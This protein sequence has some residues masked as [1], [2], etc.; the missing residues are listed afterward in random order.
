MRIQVIVLDGVFDTGLAT[1]LDA[2]QTA[3][4]LAEMFSLTS[5]RFDVLI[6]GMR[7][8]VKT[9]QGL[10]VPVVPAPS[11]VIPDWV[12]VPA[13]GFKMPGPLQT[14]LERSNVS[15]PVCMLPSPVERGAAAAAAC[16]GTFVLAG[17][18]LLDN[19]D[20]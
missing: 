8:A 4:E 20:A 18:G 3:N 6:V 1:L 14:A 13:I 7:R 5:M 16:V 19:H 15:H 9:S 17:S 2:F 10:I 12:V 11:R